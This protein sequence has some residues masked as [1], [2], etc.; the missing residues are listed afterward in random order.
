VRHCGLAH[1]PGAVDIDLDRL[2][3]DLV[4]ERSVIGVIDPGGPA[5]VV[6]ED[7]ESAETLDRALDERLTLRLVGDVALDLVPLS[8][9]RRCDGPTRL[10]RRRRVHDNVRPCGG[11]GMSRCLADA[12]RRA[13]DECNLAVQ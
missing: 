12:A 6:D 8:R 3:E 9:Q 5:G 7:V 1:P 2:E 11:E 4:G 13:C 10:D